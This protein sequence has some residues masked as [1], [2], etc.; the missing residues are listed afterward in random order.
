VSDVVDRVVEALNAHDLDA[1]VGCY[2]E[3]ATIEDGY[4]G[5]LASGHAGI[6]ARYGPLLAEHPDARWTV[7]ARID[8]GEFVVQHEEVT[9]RGETSRH[10]CVYQVR[11]QRV[12]RERI[13]R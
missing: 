5:V 9:G 8:S 7:L 3:Q 13:L 4:D 1:F 10:V 11:D 6:R 2:A 12:A